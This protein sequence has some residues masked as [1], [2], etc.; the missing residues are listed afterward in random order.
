VKSLPVIFVAALSASVL[1]RAGE[2][3]A[4]F[5]VEPKGPFEFAEKPKI[6]RAGDKVTI[7]FAAKAACDVTVAIEAPPARSGGAPRIIRHLASGV[8]GENAPP[9]LAKGTLKQSIVWDGKD[10]AG[11]YFDDKDS[12][13]VRVSLGLKPQFEKTLYWSPHKRISN[14]APL[15]A[16]APEGVYV[17][18][19]LGVDH[20][21]LFGRDGTYLRTI[22]P[23]PADRVKDVIGLQTHEFPQDG[24]KMPLKLGF[25]QSTLLSSGSSGLG[26]EGGHA[27]GYAATAMAIHP[28]TGDLAKVGR[29]RI[30][31]VYQTVNRLAT[32]GTSGGLPLKGPECGYKVRVRKIMRPV[33]P[34]SAAFDPQG[35]YLYMT[36]YVWKTGAH[37]GQ[38]DCYHVVKRMEYAKNDPPRDFLGVSKTDDGWG[39]GKDRFCVPTSVACDPKGRV[40]VADHVNSRVQVFSPEG[41]L[42]RSIPTPFPSTLRIDPRS[43]EIFSYSWAV[44]GP[45]SK[46]W[47]E[48]DYPG[49]SL[50][51]TLARLGTFEK[52]VKSRPVPLPGV[53][54]SSSGGWIATGG[55]TFQAVTDFFSKERTT[56]IVG[57]KA[58]VSVAEANWMGGGGM[59]THLG[60]WGERG[61]R[62]FNLEG[63]EWKT[64][65]DFAKTAAEKVVR[66]T[67]AQFS[68][69]RLVADPRTGRL[70]VIEEQTGPGKSFYTVMRVDPA[71]GKVKEI[72]LPFD[73]EDMVFDM[74]G[75]VYLKTDREVVR[76]DPRNWRE[77]PWDYG[78]MRKGIG[79]AASGALPKHN[80]PSALAIPGR[81]PVWYHS[82]GMW[83]SPKRHLAVV[84]NVRHKPPERNPKDKYFQDGV[85]KP[86]APPVYPGR[87]GS[88]VVLIFDKHGK[89]IR[90]DALPGLTNGDG[91]GIDSAG[92]LYVLVAAPRVFDGKRYFN[93]KSETLMKFPPGKGRFISAGRARIQLPEE[94]RPKRSP[95][96]TKFGMGATWAEGAEW[97]YGG[98]GYGGQGGSCTCWHARFQLDY[99]ARS[100]VPEVRRFKV[101]VLDSAGNLVLRLGRYGNV[102]D[103]KPLDPAG[104]PEKPRPLG[105]DEVSLAHAAYVG[106]HTDRRLFI[107]DAGNG[108]VLSVKLDYHATEKVALK[109]VRDAGAK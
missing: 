53:S 83:V 55:Q 85:T 84:C 24:K 71:S 2:T 107:H 36:G 63:K 108:R 35:K 101:A 97:M 43:G 61:I 100:F 62:L 82:T 15:M 75:I 76:F 102:D 66:V 51:P 16:V 58:T 60:G 80:S 89:L 31:L 8:L 1:A 98:V 27:G 22:Y 39:S 104:G 26:G 5:R 79:F 30:A 70:Y 109:D 92:N 74:E 73:A 14:M 94:S 41:K 42:L 86:Y 57:R 96:V 90:E 6:T 46:V 12:L 11:R 105:G 18:E 52:P 34:T 77:L 48:K 10:D 44:I 17:F 106:V 23:F 99:F 29:R 68:R 65:A 69:Q 47:R 7:S 67:P 28:P 103:G 88:R 59:W 4:E 19:G 3:P 56:W 9:P 20:L 25:E 91:I 87:S 13:T 50:K 45:S 21:R 81:R 93:E 54:A 78:E 72:K 95:D 40:Y 64:A 49:R 37:H 32:D 33:G 38:A